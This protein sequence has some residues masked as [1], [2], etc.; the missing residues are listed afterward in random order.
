MSLTRI[1]TNSGF[2]LASL[3]Y[4]CSQ[5]MSMPN[6]NSNPPPISENINNNTNN[7]SSNENYNEN[8]NNN[9]NE[10]SS[11][12]SELQEY[13]NTVIN[14]FSESV[15]EDYLMGDASNFDKAVVVGG[16]CPI[17]LINEENL[18]IK[19]EITAICDAVCDFYKG[20]LQWSSSD[21]ETCEDFNRAM[22]D[23]CDSNPEECTCV[24]C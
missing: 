20:E 2:G 21:L 10:S 23:I 11:L 16:N 15:M 24:G 6:E 14:R 12:G 7:N 3:L 13:Y 18:S 19:N 22:Y 4:G 8:T 9:S 1:L 17:L 5:P